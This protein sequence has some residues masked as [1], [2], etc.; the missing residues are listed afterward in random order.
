MQLDRFLLRNTPLSLRQIRREIIAGRVVVDGTVCRDILKAITKFTQVTWRDDVLQNRK[1]YYVMLNKPLGTV[2][3][4]QHP[5]HKTIVD[6]ITTDY[7]ALLHYAGR[8]DFNTTGLMLLTSDGRW[9]RN[10]TQPRQKIPKMYLVET[11]HPIDEQYLAR[12]SRPMY[13]AY[14]NITLMPAE[15]IQLDTRQARVTIYEGRYH[16]IKRMFGFFNNPVVT[17]HRERI[18]DLYLDDQLKPGQFRDL[19]ASERGLCLF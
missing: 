19:T 8:L 16:Q 7:A 11:E 1:A 2:S 5:H 18:G 9:S 13:F 10:L 6:C 3:A 15:F 12:F 17:L 4:T 14:E